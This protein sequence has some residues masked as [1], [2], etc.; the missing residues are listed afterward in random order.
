MPSSIQD[1]TFMEELQKGGYNG[2]AIKALTIALL[3][4]MYQFLYRS[5]DPLLVHLGLKCT[6]PYYNYL[7]YMLMSM[8]V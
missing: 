5:P 1:R 2:N 4:P 6:R 3:Y 8:Y 7:P